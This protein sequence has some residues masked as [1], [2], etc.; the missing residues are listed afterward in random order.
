MLR[1]RGG[2][3]VASRMQSHHRR[4]D[5]GT[6]AR[7]QQAIDLAGMGGSRVASPVFVVG[8][9]R[10]GTTL[11]G[12]L[13]GCHPDVAYLNE[14]RDLWALDPR[15]DAWKDGEGKIV[16]SADDVT[17]AVRQRLTAGFCDALRS[18]GRTRIVEKTPINSFR[19]GYLNALWPD[20][21]FLHIIRDGRAVARSIASRSS[22]PGAWLGTR[23][24]L[25][26]P[27]A[28]RRERWYGTADSKWRR[29]RSLAI[30]EGIAVGEC[31]NDDFVA[32]GLVEW[33][34]AVEFAQ[35]T[36]V[37]L[38]P[39]RW[40]ELRYEELLAEPAQCMERVLEAT[41]L[42]RC[43]RVIDN[44]RHR[45]RATHSAGSSLSANHAAI[46]GRLLEALGYE[47]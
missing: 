14:P 11:I 28:G 37:T 10:S 20:A 4:A 30:D 47:P 18:T 44:A 1:N 43:E 33:R 19:I 8:C 9:G 15:T 17:S 29:L 6:A 21:R 45:V 31:A 22:R 36:L 26:R 40:A 25:R 27:G 7:G 3:A 42:A 12:E 46:A 38:T 39:S 34:L 13:L 16:L 23:E 41:G 5:G 2:D 32:R 35:R 24:A